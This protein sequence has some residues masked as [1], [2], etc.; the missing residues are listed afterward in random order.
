[1]LI[2]Q[3]ILEITDI[4]MNKKNFAPPNPKIIPTALYD[5]YCEVNLCEWVMFTYFDHIL[6]LNKSIHFARHFSY[7]STNPIYI[8]MIRDPLQRLVSSYY[9]IRNH[10]QTMFPLSPDRV[11]MVNLITYTHT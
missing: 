4:L 9:F 11:A 2:D 10:L 7:N 5:S 3:W 1:M 8:N 6:H